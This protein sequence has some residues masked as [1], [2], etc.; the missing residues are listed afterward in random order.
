MEPILSDL[1]PP[2][3]P[4]IDPAASRGNWKNWAGGVLGIVILCLGIW[5]VR[6]IAGQV[7]IADVVAEIRKTPVPLLV[8]AAASTALSYVVLMFYDWFATRHL[9]YRLRWPTIAAASFASFTLAHT[10]GLTALTGGTVRYRIYSRVGVKAGDVAAIVLMCGWT[11]W[12]G[13][14]SVAGLGLLVSP[15]LSKPFADFLPGIE[16]WTGAIML[17]GVLAYLALATFWRRDFHLWR[18]RFILPD[19][20]STLLQIAIGMIDLAFAGGALFLLLP[21]VGT[22]GLLSVLTIYGVAM[23]SGAL[24]HAPGGLGVFEAVILLLMPEAPKSGVLA[25]LVIW[26]MFYTYI[27]FLIGVAVVAWGEWQALRRLRAERAAGR[28]SADAAAAQPNRPSRA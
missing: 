1:A 16:R 5:G 7:T 4:A 17:G 28:I 18:Y 11:F 14:V 2:P 25:A 22:P 27:P 8:A 23:V 20:R 21:E 10:L 15:D 24:A 19:G 12:L 13:V 6:T 3:A 9:G 26:R